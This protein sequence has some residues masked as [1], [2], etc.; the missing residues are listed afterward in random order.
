MPVSSFE[1]ELDPETYACK[2]VQVAG[3]LKAFAF[4]LEDIAL[5]V[6]LMLSQSE[7]KPSRNPNGILQ[8]STA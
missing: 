5:I 8:P 4:N 7:V 6:D 1:P 2:S 3:S